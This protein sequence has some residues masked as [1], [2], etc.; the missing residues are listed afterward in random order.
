M[1]DRR[2]VD[3]QDRAAAYAATARRARI[4]GPGVWLEPLATVEKWT[5]Q[6]E[7]AQDQAAEE[8]GRRLG[9]GWALRDVREWSCGLKRKGCDCTKGRRFYDVTKKSGEKVR[10]LGYCVLGCHPKS[11]THR[12]AL[13]EHLPTGAEFSLVPGQ[14]VDVRA[15]FYKAA[16]ASI[17]ALNEEDDPDEAERLLR[18]RKRDIS[19]LLVARWPV[20]WGQARKAA[21]ST[22]DLFDEGVPVTGMSH[23]HASAWFRGRGLRLPSSAEWQHAALGGAPTRFPW[24]DE[25]DLDYVWCAENSGEPYPCTACRGEGF[26]DP[27]QGSSVYRD[28]YDGVCVLCGGSAYEP[29][30]ESPRPHPP[31]EH[32]AAGKHNAFGLVDTVGNVW[33]WLGDGGLAGDAYNSQTR[34]INGCRTIPARTVHDG[35]GQPNYGFRPVC[36]VPDWRAK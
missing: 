11:Q 12:L 15:E 14:A 18:A 10:R 26:H 25:V 7:E 17:R 31:A 22:G 5:A 1:K 27:R 2:V 8:V 4:E 33:E 16:N 6:P 9:S 24:G 28:G 30:S 21:Q 36:D 3:T 20:T 29:G 19:P 32:D 23:L 35:G 34:D 13:F